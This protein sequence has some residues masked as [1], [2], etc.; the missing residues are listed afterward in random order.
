[1]EPGNYIG[2]LVVVTT[3]WV[4]FDSIS[5]GVRRGVIGGRSFGDMGIVLWVLWCLLL[6]I[7]AFPLYLA[8]R[9]KYVALRRE[10]P[11]G[12][13][14]RA[15]ARDGDVGISDELAETV[16]IGS[17]GDALE[18]QLRLLGELH[19]TGVL[20]RAELETKNA[21]LLARLQGELGTDNE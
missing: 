13:L 9:P 14:P 21:E 17:S 15:I 19:A 8:T 6:W 11:T 20:T 2:I 16:L 5:L 12:P 4:L 10:F 3:I 18:G 7:I 1:M